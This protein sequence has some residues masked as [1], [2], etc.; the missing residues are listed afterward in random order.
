MNL[1]RFYE[2]IEKSCP[3]FRGIFY[4]HS[5]IEMAYDL[6]KTGCHLIMCSDTL[7]TGLKSLGFDGF[8]SISLNLWPERV[9]EIYDYM[10]HWKL[11]EA[12]EVHNK[13]C[14]CIRE[15]CNN[16]LT[17][18]DWVEAF[19]LKF[20]KVVDFN[21]GGLRQPRCTWWYNRI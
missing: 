15:I 7:F 18:C 10:C 20:T 5:D 1:L 3:N 14:D 19:K 13:L 8:C 6:L 12:Y 4:R 17:Y 9:M 2:L 11:R 21:V 16:K